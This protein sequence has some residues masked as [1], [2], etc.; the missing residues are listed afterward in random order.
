[1]PDLA[2]S[3]VDHRLPERMHTHHSASVDPESRLAEMLGARE[4]TVCSWH[5]QAIRRLAPGLRP[6]A[7]AEDGV[8]EA[9]EHD[10]NALCVA[11]QWHPEMQLDDPAQ[12]RLLRAFVNLAASRPSP[13]G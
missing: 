5:H 9:V 12:G 2:G 3:T 4:V 11:V 1:L 13:R 10:E 8:I 6:V 7:W